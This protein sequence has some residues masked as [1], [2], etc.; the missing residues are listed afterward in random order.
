MSLLEGA[1]QPR[2]LH[3]GFCLEQ[4]WPGFGLSVQWL[5]SISVME[6]DCPLPSSVRGTIG[7]G[8][9]SATFILLRDKFG[10]EIVGSRVNGKRGQ[11]AKLLER[12]SCPDAQKCCPC[13]MFWLV[14]EDHERSYFNM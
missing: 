13:G 3:P 11:R 8:H 4:V 6:Q 5:G 10:K 7:P 2:G 9:K 1:G 14:T 12:V